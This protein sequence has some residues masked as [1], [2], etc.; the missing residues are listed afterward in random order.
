MEEVFG[1]SRSYKE[2]VGGPPITLTHASDNSSYAVLEFNPYVT[3]NTL[4]V[5]GYYNTSEGNLK[6]WLSRHPI[7]PSRSDTASLQSFTLTFRYRTGL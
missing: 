2:D 1:P 3:P 5:A 7:N 4:K 6:P